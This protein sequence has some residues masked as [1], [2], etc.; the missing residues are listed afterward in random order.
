MRKN[1]LLYVTHTLHILKITLSTNECTKWNTITCKSSYTIY[2]KYQTPTCFRTVVPFSGSLRTKE[3]QS[4]TPSTWIGVPKHVAVWYLSWI[5]F[6]DLYFIVAYSVHLLVS[7][8]HSSPFLI[9]FFADFSSSEPCG[10]ITED[11]HLAGVSWALLLFH[12]SGSNHQR[13][14][15]VIFLSAN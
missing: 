3:Y 12:L 4:N 5:V 7:I 6:Y 14:S 13:K 15:S 9:I 8:V 1:L 10:C 11:L 2:E